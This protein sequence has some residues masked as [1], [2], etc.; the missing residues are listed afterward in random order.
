MLPPAGIFSTPR[1]TL[2]LAGTAP[3]VAALA[4]LLPPPGAMHIRLPR[5]TDNL[6]LRNTG[7]ASIFISFHSGQ[8]EYELPTA[9]QE[10]FWDS[11]MSD[12]YIRGNGATV[13]FRMDIA[14]VNGEMA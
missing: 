1:P 3:N 11:A 2:T 6:S 14:I 5:F 12:V 8:P 13:T 9:Q 7:G 10:S 4:T